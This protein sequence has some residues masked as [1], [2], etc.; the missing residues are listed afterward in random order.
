MRK[1]LSVICSCLIL[2]SATSCGNFTKPE[3]KPANSATVQ[4]AAGT[5]TQSTAEKVTV[6]MKKMTLQQKIAQMLQGAGFRLT[7]NDMQKYCYGSVLN[8][9]NS[10]SR[11]AATWLSF[12]EGYQK[13]AMS[14]KLPV[15]CL[16][17]LECNPWA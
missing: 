4:A 10:R 6:L 15:P 17:G 12:V 1:I 9:G 13:A 16:Y 8:G 3:S 7:Y 2:F 14:S 5:N 11:D